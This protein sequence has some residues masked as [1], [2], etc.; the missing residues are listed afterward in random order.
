MT[1]IN[2]NEKPNL[3]RLYGL[4]E[5]DKVGTVILIVNNNIIANRRYHGKYNRT[6]IMKSWDDDF[7]L[8]GKELTI[9]IQPDI[10]C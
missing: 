3:K 1:A 8:K 5:Y 9:I 7:D 2:I 4:C 6:K 10:K